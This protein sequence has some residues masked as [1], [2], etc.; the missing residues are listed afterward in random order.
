MQSAR[1]LRF[2]S[3]L[4]FV[5]VVCGP[6]SGLAQELA[7]AP[8]VRVV[9]EGEG[10]PL[11]DLPTV[12]RLL[13]LEWLDPTT[14]QGRVTTTVSL[15]CE[16][17]NVRVSL[18]DRGQALR[19]RVIEVA[20]TEWTV[21]PRIVALVAAQLATSIEREQ[22]ARAEAVARAARIPSQI[23]AAD[24]TS[25]ERRFS[26]EFGGGARVWQWER[27]WFAA[28]VTGA[29]GM[30]VGS[31]PLFVGAA[32]EGEFATLAAALGVVSFARG[33][34]GP[35]VGWAS[36]ERSTVRAH[37]RA[38]IAMGAQ[39][40]WATSQRGDVTAGSLVAFA[41]EG[42]LR[43]GVSVRVASPLA[44]GLDVDVA[45]AAPTLEGTL[46]DSSV[47]RAG[48]LSLG[49]HLALRVGVR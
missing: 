35:W 1:T 27:P 21:A 43:T 16:A 44:L 7:P 4:G 37:A 40:F 30:R 13:A 25:A 26:I 34:T 45:Y 20:P 18:V 47:L 12:G 3:A 19:T 39:A 22:R 41:L 31:L 2:V 36:S 14:S 10:C 28:S 32:V 15:A 11:L 24:T 38:M 29:T 5:C 6:A 46:G 17:S 49:A 48:G 9:T 42:R 8:T 23:P 33:V